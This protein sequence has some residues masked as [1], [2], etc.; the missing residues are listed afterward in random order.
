M[1]RLR[2]LPRPNS[3]AIPTPTSATGHQV[4][5]SGQVQVRPAEVAGE[6]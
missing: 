1:R 6:A 4:S 5:S 3:I 2:Y